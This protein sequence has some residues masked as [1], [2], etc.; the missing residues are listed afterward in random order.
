MTTLLLDN[1]HSLIRHHRAP[2]GAGGVLAVTFAEMFLNDPDKPGFGQEFLL[3]SGFDVVTVQKRKE[4]WYQDL[5]VETF[6][7]AVAPVARDYARVVTYGVSMGGF[8]AL[9]FAGSLDACALALS[10]RVSILPHLPPTEAAPR[11]GT[12]PLL[13]IHLK[14]APR[15][16][17][18]MLVIYDPW[19]RLDQFYLDQEVLPAFPEARIVPVPWAGHPVS[20]ALG[21]MGLLPSLVRGFVAHGVV[22]ARHFERPH[23]A[24]SA[25]YLANLGGHCGRHGHPALGLRL[26]DRAI[27]LAEPW[28]RP[29]LEERRAALAARRGRRPRGGGLQVAEQARQEQGEFRDEGHQQQGA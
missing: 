16:R 15:G 18:T 9:L 26:F 5:P 13:H 27:A 4:L 21:E 20:R 8:A 12:V 1:G 7:A 2:Q 11:R 19:T 17:G 29:R 3:K 24:R 6:R 23:R 14:D 10:P 25:V 22:P 28:A